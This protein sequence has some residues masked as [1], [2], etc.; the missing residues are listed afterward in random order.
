MAELAPFPRE[1]ALLG[2]V[3]SFTVDQIEVVDRLRD[4]HVRAAAE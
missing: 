2:P 4:A 3:E 1:T